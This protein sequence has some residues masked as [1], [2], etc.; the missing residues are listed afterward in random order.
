MTYTIEEL[1]EIAFAKENEAEAEKARLKETVLCAEITFPAKMQKELGITGYTMKASEIA[2]MIED[3]LDNGDA[4]SLTF[5][6]KYFY[7]TN[8]WIEN[9]PEANI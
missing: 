7:K 9:I 1:R 3:E 4:K 2:Q 8:K 5:T 6:V